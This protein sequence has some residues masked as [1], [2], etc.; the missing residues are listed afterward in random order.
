[1]GG[2][3]HPAS[4]STAQPLHASWETAAVGAPHLAAAAW[5]LSTAPLKPTTGA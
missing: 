4:S 1:M 2:T 3:A 5:R